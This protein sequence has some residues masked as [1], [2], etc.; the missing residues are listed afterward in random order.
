[1][2]TDRGLYNSKNE[3]DSCGVG[4]IVNPDGKST[5][6]TV[7]DGLSILSNL[8]HRG[9][10]GG[11][12]KTGDGAGITLQI[13]DVFFRKKTDISLPKKGS[14]GVGFLFMSQRE[15]Q[16][17]KSWKI[18][19]NAVKKENANIIGCREVPAESSLLGDIALSNMPY[20]KQV[21]IEYG[22]I[23]GDL[24]ERK[25]YLLRRIIEKEMSEAGMSIDEFYI[26]SM[27]SRTIVYKGMFLAEQFEKFFPD[28]KDGDFKSTFAIV[29]QRYSTNTLPS[30]PLAQPFRC[31]AHNG[32]INTLKGNINHMKARESSLRS[33]HYGED[34][35]K[36]IPVINEQGSDSAVLDNV[37]E[38]LLSAG[39]RPEHAMMMMIPEAFGK[40][41]SAGEDKR[42]FYEY[43]ASIMEPWDGPAAVVFTDGVKVGAVLDRNGLR[44]AR[45][46]ITKNGRII[47]SSEAGVLPVD[48]GQV[49][50]KG[51]L[52]PGKMILVDTRNSR[53]MKDSEI[54][55]SVFCKRPYR[56]WLEN[57]KIE[58]KDMLKPSGEIKNHSGSILTK[59]RVF[60][61]TFEDLNKIIKPM[62]IN[63]QEP[64]GSM[65]D[66]ETLSVLS[67]R[68]K[69]LYHYFKQSFAQ[70]TNPP[71]DPYRESLVMSL[72]SFIGRER[73]LLTE[74]PQHCR[75]IK[76]AHPVLLRE[77][78]NR[79]M[80]A[81][82]NGLKTSKVHIIFRFDS[83]KDSMRRSLRDICER[84]EHEIDNGAEVV[85]LSDRNTD[86]KNAPIPALLATSAVNNYLIRKGKRHL[87]GLVLETGEVRG[88]MDFAVLMGFGANAIN[89]YLAFETI[90]HMKENGYLPKEIRLRK[91]MDNYVKAIKK[92]VLKIMSKMGVS[93]IRSYRGAQLFEAV[94][95]NAEFL[96][97]Y[98][99][100]VTSQI[101][102]AGI[103]VIARETL[104][105]HEEAYKNENTGIID[106]GGSHNYRKGGE[107]HLMTPEAV[108]TL[109]KAVR[110]GDYDLYKKYS[111]IINNR[112]KDMCTL[113][114]LFNFKKRK[115]VPLE[116]V[117]KEESII[118]RFYASAMSFGSISRETHETIARAM[119][120]IGAQSN[121]GEGG[122]DEKRYTAF[123]NPEST[124]SMVKQ[125][126][127][128]RFGVTNN[129]IINAKEIQ[130][131]M[132]QGA[133]PGEGG[134]LPGHK[135]NYEI[136]SVRNST[137][138]V[139]LISPPPHHDIYS[140]EDLAQLIYDI[141]NTNTRARVS[142][143]LV[144]KSGVGTVAAGVAKGKADMV[145]ISGADG[146]TGASPLSSIKHAGIPWEIGLSET[147]Q[148]LIRNRLRSRIRIQVDGQIRTAK[149]VMVGAM[150]GAEEFGFG[151]IVLVTLGCIM[152]RKCHANTC[153]VGIATQDPELRKRFAGKPEHLSNYMIFLARE[154]REKMAEL[155]LRSFDEMVGRVDFIDRE[156]AEGH[157]KAEGLD[158]SKVL[159]N[160]SLYGKKSVRCTEKQNMELSGS[161]NSRII[162][163]SKEAVDKRKKTS[164]SYTIKNQD[165]SVGA[166]LSGI[167]SERYGAKGLPPDTI[168]VNLRG[169]AGQSFG[170]FLVRGVTL[171]LEGDANDYVGKG[172]SG[173][174][175]VI[176]PDRRSTF[177]PQRNIIAGN[178]NL[179]GA[180]S[181]EA[182]I[183]GC[184]GER[185]AV[186]NSGATA[187]VEGVGDHGCEY[188]TGGKVVV[189]GKT[190]VNFAAGMSGGLAYVLD[191]DGLF[192]TRC[193]LDMVVLEPVTGKQD[194]SI[195]YRLIKKHVN[196]TKSPYAS[197]ILDKWEEKI[198]KFVK[199]FPVDYK[200]AIRRMGDRRVNDNR[201]KKEKEEV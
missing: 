121:S 176:F 43:H 27:S 6:K 194:L 38:L 26:P 200:K 130:I 56:Q 84:V 159:Y 174:N 96:D 111:S 165:R 77:D 12:L 191:E 73:N 41:Y 138:G 201:F 52:A 197:K 44:P 172:L 171:K 29:H 124:M 78:I 64:I 40:E 15:K 175:I 115:P 164:L 117:E 7:R 71:I 39:R 186:R 160:A 128:G 76:L 11:D 147:Q 120:S 50:E 155:G 54:K 17:K 136:A 126:A 23:S 67:E 32:E 82:K 142:V 140:I 24:L 49:L 21:F 65:G 196:L 199:V 97:E 113:R 88:V 45:Y 83:G 47:L 193:N 10:T 177:K 75:Q 89:P 125:L 70:V 30:W 105:R 69:L 79:L 118:K 35:K 158:F 51:R 198:D 53:I 141:K 134:Q 68:P 184:A 4:F 14:Y 74:T 168:K 131:K 123:D 162:K 195:L 145:L 183:N 148:T 149:D 61:Y 5:N 106:S 161:V 144:S 137:P 163:D 129:Y 33:S 188:M 166:E 103:D 19:N 3:Q 18:I 122:E 62:V 99:E 59:H 90:S 1:L 153:P 110:E 112:S 173:G 31:L 135:V 95:L 185:F 42:S 37:F 182:Y 146:G 22:G 152:V 109:Q 156:R 66:D 92:G 48:E 189:L 104:M 101:E 86:S 16:R 157:W 143:K 93:T 108:I 81:E 46:V 150:L 94:G 8:K 57:N 127:S 119:N 102:G 60:G 167:I 13:P 85:V 180:T 114:G 25:L 91:A 2:K 133:K 190:G 9:A 151:T 192:N 28:L 178:V 154:I 72:M 20:M 107:N 55:A 132:A 116:E 181:G 36:A 179:F 170:A 80:D 169:S 100:G 34:I 187:V 58:I 139:M 63:A 87:A 98:F